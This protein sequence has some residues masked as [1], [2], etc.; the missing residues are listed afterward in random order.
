MGTQV[1]IHA[2]GVGLVVAEVDRVEKGNLL[3]G[4]GS[5]AERAHECVGADLAFSE[6]FRQSP[7]RDVPAKIHL[8]EPVLRMHVALGEKQVGGGLRGDLGNSGV[9]AGDRDRVG[10]PRNVD[11]AGQRRKR[12]RD[13]PDPETRGDHNQA[14]HDTERDHYPPNATV[15][16]AARCVGAHITPS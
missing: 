8:P 10:E 16:P 11:G 13:R 6:Q 2:I 9:I 12:P 1:G 3:L 5:P 4:D 15:P 7:A 14:D